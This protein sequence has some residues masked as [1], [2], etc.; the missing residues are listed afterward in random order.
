MSDGFGVLADQRQGDIGV[1]NDHHWQ[2]ATATQVAAKVGTGSAITAGGVSSGESLQILQ[3][4]VTKPVLQ[5]VNLFVSRD[6]NDTNIG[7]DLNAAIWGVSRN[8]GTSQPVGIR[9]EAYG[10]GNSVAFY[11]VASDAGSSGGAF[12]AFLF[13]KATAAGAGAIGV[14]LNVVNTTGGDSAYSAGSF[15]GFDA[16]YDAGAA[17]KYAGA[18]HYIRSATPGTDKWDAGFYLKGDSIRT[19]GYLDETSSVTAISITGPHSNAAIS[20]SNA[21]DNYMQKW[22]RTAAVVA[23]YGLHVDASGALGIDDVINAAPKFYIAL[24]T[25]GANFTAVYIQEGATPTLRRLKTFD[26]GAAG[27]N[28][29]AGQLVCVLV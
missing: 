12:G 13:A 8:A 2:R 21:V 28:F 10:L 17:G 18:A 15:V 23:S 11:G 9:G 4:S 14:G 16:V 19:V 27:A 29:T 7:A 26:P 6:M 1:F 20:I 25:P 22:S 5:G 24:G 3:G